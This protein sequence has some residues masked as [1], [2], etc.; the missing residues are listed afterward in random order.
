MP[1][2]FNDI[3]IFIS[4]KHDEER[5]FN[6]ANQLSSFFNEWERITCRLIEN[7]ESTVPASDLISQK[8]EDA[9]YLIQIINKRNGPSVWMKTEWDA[10]GTMAGL[11]KEKMHKPIAFYT[12]IVNLND[13]N[14][15]YLKTALTTQKNKIINID[16]QNAGPTI[17]GILVETGR[18]S[19]KHGGVTVPD[20]CLKHNDPDEIALKA[21]YEFIGNFHH[22]H[23]RGLL[24]VYPNKDKAMER[25]APM[26]EKIADGDTI[27]MIGFTLHRF[28]HPDHNDGIGKS[29]LKAIEKENV[30]AQLLIINPDCS[31]AQERMKVE[32]KIIDGN[33]TEA[34]L[35]IDSKDVVSY[36]KHEKFNNKVEIKY[37]RTPYSGIVIL[38]D[39]LFLECYH[40]GHDG[41][42]D[43]GKTICGR[44]PV[45]F[46]KK[47]S[48]FYELYNSHFTRLWERGEV[49]D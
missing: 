31:A 26:L 23:K 34:I 48:P 1:V 38:D 30:K 19:P 2:Q 4:Y 32:S 21:L 12:N 5:S 3:N 13:N 43:D 11:T 41:I 46:F 40:L 45:M 15:E 35:S 25:L 33:Y 9:D 14:C 44:V 18:L 24:G 47:G 28:V 16:T 22:A 29:F 36:Y 37:Y 17:I 8:L 49:V 27:K 7:E 39:I 20:F 10:A 42:E 6:I